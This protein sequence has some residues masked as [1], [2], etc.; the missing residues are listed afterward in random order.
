MSDK[1]IG[2]RLVSERN[3]L[4]I[5]QIELSSLLDITPVTTRKY[6]Q[7]ISPI[8]S[9]KLEILHQKGFDINYIITGK[10]RDVA[11]SEEDKNLKNRIIKKSN[12][13]VA[14][15]EKLQKIEVAPDIYVDIDDYAWIPLYNVKVSAG[16]G[17]FTDRENII[18]WLSMTKYSL[19]MRG[20][21]AKDLGAVMVHG[22]S[23]HDTLKSN[24]CIFVNF[25]KRE[26]DGGIFVLRVGEML[27]V[28]R[29]IAEKNTISVISDN[30][31][32]DSWSLNL[33]DDFDIIGKYEWHGR[34]AD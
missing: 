19:R 9:D 13:D 27:H 15:F 12:R 22:D 10:I 5:K 25:T 8:P 29:L 26:P 6:E 32:Y 17:R 7:G 1:K 3:R 33:D 24:D 16:D 20:L 4:E 2:E 28:K 14:D 11:G 18:T 23:M 34:Y 31:R 30:D 21:S